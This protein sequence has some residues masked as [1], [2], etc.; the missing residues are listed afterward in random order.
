MFALSS[1]FGA[2]ADRLGPR[3][4]MGGGPAAR[5]RRACSCCSTS[6]VRRRLRDRGPP[7]RSSCSRW[8]CSMTVAP[9][10]AAILAGVREREAGIG[11]A[12]QQRG[13]TRRGPDRDGRGRRGRGGAVQLIARSAACR[14]TAHR[15][16]AGG[17]RGSQATDARSPVGRRPPAARGGGDHSRIGPVLARGVP[18]SASASPAR[19]SSIGGLI[20]AAGIR[21]PQRKVRA[22]RVLR[23]AACRSTTRRRRA[24]RLRTSLMVGAMSAASGA[25]F[26]RFRS[27]RR[28]P[29]RSPRRA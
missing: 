26:R 28:S 21:N 19:S 12:R 16:R 3:L 5:R 11:S 22:Q 9:L 27:Q 13:R 6:G 23:R 17:R 10:T 4:F 14:A 20:G 24:T 1:R 7:R 15:W 8:V 29:A 2:L 18:C 25:S